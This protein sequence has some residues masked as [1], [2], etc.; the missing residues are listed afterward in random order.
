MPKLITID[1]IVN[2]IHEHT[3]R[4]G[5][6]PTNLYLGRLDVKELKLMTEAYGLRSMYSPEKGEV[7]SQFYGLFIYEVDDD[8]HLAV[9]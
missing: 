2:K 6:E 1:T 9:S 8:H 5:K 4:C 7:R 3:I